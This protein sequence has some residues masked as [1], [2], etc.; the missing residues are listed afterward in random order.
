MLGTLAL[1]PLTVMLL[2]ILYLVIGG[3][4][5]WLMG[6]TNLFEWSSDESAALTWAWICWLLWPL[7]TVGLLIYYTTNS[8]SFFVFRAS[9]FVKIIANVHCKYGRHAG[10][11]TEARYEEE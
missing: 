2:V 9:K 5:T 4:Q 1:T 8:I 11:R 7:T 10:R 6:K 3:V